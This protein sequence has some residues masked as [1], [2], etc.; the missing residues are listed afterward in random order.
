MVSADNLARELVAPAVRAQHANALG[1]ATVICD[2]RTGIAVGAK[3]LAGEKGEAGR[4]APLPNSGSVGRRA[5]RLGRVL[6]DVQAILARDVTN[7]SMSA[8]CPFMWTGMM[9]FL[10]SVIFASTS[11]GS[12]Q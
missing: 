5:V 9:A 6:N 10:R 1:E 3:I 12:Q 2:H 11:A 7:A 8:G 4:R